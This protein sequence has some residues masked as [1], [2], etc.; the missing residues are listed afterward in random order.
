MLGTD[1]AVVQRVGWLGTSTAFLRTMML[2]NRRVRGSVVVGDDA[3][4]LAT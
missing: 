4:W 2:V 1:L 3:V